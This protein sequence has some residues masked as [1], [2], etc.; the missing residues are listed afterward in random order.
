MDILDILARARTE[1][2][3]APLPDD[4]EAR[5]AY[6]LLW[7]LLTSRICLED[8][9]K[10][11]CRISIAVGMGCWTVSLYDESLAVSVDTSSPKLSDCLKLL[12]ARVPDLAAWRIAKRKKP[13]LRP[14]A[15]KT[16]KNGLPKRKK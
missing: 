8:K 1:G 3:G 11:P 13:K 16:S 12:E 5:E 10:Y 9:E 2:D 14:N 6:P 7:S 15:E 4:D